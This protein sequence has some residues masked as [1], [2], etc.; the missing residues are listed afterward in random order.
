MPPL[1]IIF[2]IFFLLVNL[3]YWVMVFVLMY[4][5]VRFGIGIQPKKFAA[6]FLLGSVILS[7]LAV[8]LFTTVDINSLV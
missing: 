5:L 8:I 1:Q 2:N 6:I 7:S 3:A 4:H